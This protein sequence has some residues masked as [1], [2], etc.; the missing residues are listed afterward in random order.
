[1]KHR[2]PIII[3]ATFI[4]AAIFAGCST[5]KYAQNYMTNEAVQPDSTYQLRSGDRINVVVQQYAKFDTTDTVSIRGDI[6]VPLVGR[7]HVAGETQPQLKQ[8][9]KRELANFINGNIMV[10]LSVRRV[11]STQVSVIGEVGH[12]NV[13]H[14]DHPVSIYKMLARA[15]GPKAD[16]NIKK[17]RLY[18]Q[19]G[20]VK[21][22]VL[23]LKHFLKHGEVAQTPKVQP[24]DI[25]YV[26]QKTNTLRIIRSVLRIFRDAFVVYGIVRAIR[27]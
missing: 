15:G 6:T 1:M 5:P 19:S 25:I 12:S 23:N 27:D 24:G 14:I 3:S 10:S 7:V 18:H 26:P 21:Y 16:A 8:K 20:E 11:S 22:N 4:L 2:L 17:V 9:L 13:Y